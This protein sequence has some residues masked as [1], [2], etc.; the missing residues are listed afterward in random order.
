MVGKIGYYTEDTGPNDDD[1]PDV[2]HLY[3]G[4]EP[5]LEQYILIK[6]EWRPLID[7]WFL[8]DKII[9][10]NPD[11]SDPMPDPPEGVPPYESA[12]NRRGESR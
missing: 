12:A 3:M 9:D 10:G 1:A 2:F 7:P 4:D 6:G 11:I 5:P 8:M